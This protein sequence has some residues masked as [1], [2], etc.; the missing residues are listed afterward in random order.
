[1]VASIN[2]A[3]FSGSDYKLEMNK[4]KFFLQFFKNE[5]ISNTVG[6]AIDLKNM[7]NAG[8]TII[9][10]CIFYNNFGPEGGSINMEEGGSLF[11]IE[12][13][14]SLDPMYLMVP[15]ELQDLI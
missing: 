2:G 9:E 6:G 11:A 14:F 5:T 12:N 4:S 7:N 3:V 1:M 10:N 8:L 13:H 15:K